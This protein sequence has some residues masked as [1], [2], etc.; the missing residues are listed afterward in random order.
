MTAPRARFGIP[1][2][3]IGLIGVSHVMPYVTDYPPFWVLLELIGMCYIFIV[4]SWF[5]FGEDNADVKYILWSVP[6][7]VFI[8]LFIFPHF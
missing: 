1:A 4:P 5:F 2:L 3:I 7:F 8:I 6:L